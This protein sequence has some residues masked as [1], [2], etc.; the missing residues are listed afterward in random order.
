M[1]SLTHACALIAGFSPKRAASATVLDSPL[2]NVK[3]ACASCETA[4]IPMRVGACRDFARRSPALLHVRAWGEAG[5]AARGVRRLLPQL[6]ALYLQ[7]A[8]A[9]AYTH[10]R[11]LLDFRRLLH[12]QVLHCLRPRFQDAELCVREGYQEL[13]ASSDQHAAAT[14]DCLCS[15]PRALAVTID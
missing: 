1:P 10:G 9:E 12:A 6:G 4:R 13:Q 2:T 5:A 7:A 15:V 3:I 14:T 11:A 8:A